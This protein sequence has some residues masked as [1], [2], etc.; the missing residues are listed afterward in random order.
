MDLVSY[1]GP[2]V[3]GGVS[4]GLGALW[5]GQENSQANWWY[6]NQG[7]LE[8]RQSNMNT[9]KF[10]AL[11]PESLI[12]GH[13]RYCNEFLWPLMHDLPQYATYHAEQHQHYNSFNK[14]IA[15]QIDVETLGNR[16][17]FVQDYQL[18]LLPQWLKA[19]GHDSLVFWHIPWP[20]N[21]PDEY[22]EAIK[23]VA[24]G[25]L[26]ANAIG[27]HINEYAENF[28]AFVAQH[29]PEYETN[30]ESMSIQNKSAGLA[31]FMHRAR[32]AAHKSFIMH[33]QRSSKNNRGTTRL[34]V[35][36]LGIDFKKWQD[37]KSAELQSS[38]PEVL[39]KLAGTNFILS[40]DRVDYT[41]SV[42]DR[43]L[44]IDRFFQD[45][46]EWVGSVTF[47]QVSGRSRAGL[48]A[49][50]DYWQ[51]CRSLAGALN[52][53]WRQ[54]DW[55]P[56]V[57]IDQPLSAKELAFLYKRA[58]SLMINA[59]RDGLNLTAKEFIACQDANPGALLLSP[60]AGAW[61]EL[62]EQSLPVSINDYEEAC[63]SILQSLSM[64]LWER[65]QR[66]L[67]MKT[68]IAANQL[69]DWWETFSQASQ[70]SH[71][72]QTVLEETRIQESAQL[73]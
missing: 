4:S 54:D 3:A 2:G 55:Q 68:C 14:H 62:G 17:H 48:P 66:S 38:T 52:N 70:T 39:Q 73:G 11:L 71:A 72:A 41:K 61:A 69:S 29:L 18:A 43:M 6:L 13:Y 36:P 33:H 8:L 23:E 25:M 51:S 56:L 16:C 9:S 64:P 47:A 37:L 21:V 44:I 12:D 7:V 32:R 58:N 19:H 10:I 46:P 27:F 40:V 57:W 49:F 15:E 60:G 1:R 67:K 20:K 63:N 5:Q 24:Q 35:H 59:V 28:M 26:G 31:T 53:T 42:Y 34:L 30:P 22:V 45:Y 50:D 65:Q